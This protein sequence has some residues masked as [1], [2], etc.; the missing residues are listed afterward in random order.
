MSATPPRHD[1]V[2]SLAHTVS[3]ASR[4]LLSPIPAS[5]DVATLNASDERLIPS[6]LE[7]GNRTSE[8]SWDPSELRGFAVVVEDVF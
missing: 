5:K 7:V 1:A 2:R 4:A 6:S 3:T 8:F